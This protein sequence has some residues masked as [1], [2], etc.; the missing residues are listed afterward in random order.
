MFDDRRVVCQCDDLNLT[1][2]LATYRA[3]V[4]RLD[5]AVI[6]LIHQKQKAAR[7]VHTLDD[8]PHRHIGKSLHIENVADLL[9]IRV[10]G[11]GGMELIQSKPAVDQSA[12]NRKQGCEDE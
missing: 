8:E 10:N 7:D 12:H 6:C 3:D 9:A 4:I 11:A 1:F 2:T 5:L